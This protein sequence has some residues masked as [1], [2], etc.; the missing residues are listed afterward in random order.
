MRRLIGSCVAVLSIFVSTISAAALPEFVPHDIGVV[1]VKPDLTDCETGSAAWYINRNGQVT[2]TS[3]LHVFSWTEGDESPRS[4]VEAPATGFAEPGGISD[5]GQIVG[6]VYPDPFREPLVAD[7]FSWT[8]TGGLVNLGS[9][10]GTYTSAAAVNNTGQVVGQSSVAGNFAGRAFLWSATATPSMRDLGSLPGAAGTP[11]PGRGPLNADAN[12]I[13][14]NGQVVGWTEAVV[15]FN[16]ETRAFLWTEA[17]GMQD[18][19]ILGRSTSVN[20]FSGSEA[21]GINDRGQV[22]GHSSTDATTIF[23]PITHAFLWTPGRGMQDLGTLGGKSSF[24]TAL[25]SSGQVVGWS[26]ATT[27]TTSP[28]RAFLWTESGGMVALGMLPDGTSSRA[29]AINDAGESVGVMSFGTGDRAVL[30]TPTGMPVDLGPSSQALLDINDRGEIVGSRHSR[31][32]VWRRLVASPTQLAVSGTGVYGAHATLTATLVS[33]GGT[34]A[35]QI[36]TFSVNGS[37]VGSATTDAHGVA[38]LSAV[39]LAGMNAGNYP[40]SASFAGS[41]LYLSSSAQ[42]VLTVQKANQSITFSSA[43]PPSATVGAGFPVE[44]GATSDLPVTVAV[45][46]ACSISGTTV[47]L[48]RPPGVCAITADQAGDANYHPAPQATQTTTVIYDFTGFFRP[49][50]NLPAVNGVKAGSAV[51]VKFSLNGNQTLAVLDGVPTSMAIACGS[52]AG[53]MIEPLE[54]TTSGGLSYDSVTDQ[55]VYVWKTEKAWAGTCRQLV[56]RLADGTLRWANF[57]LK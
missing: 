35:D 31:A 30:W 18:L 21:T 44:A 24:P 23:D 29:H 11:P 57:D 12:A 52:T 54:T 22:I 55:Y 40:V 10:G 27:A 38:T 14:D 4:I 2:G 9:L 45:A 1:C 43:A 16:S 33:A 15:G 36:V 25:N 19:G 47:T 56:V 46:G 5:S 49:V 8:S 37:Q 39:S 53:N 20:A 3:G 48:G 42:G 28:D 13:N 34:P 41:D 51:P 6:R 17:T 7:G 32:T 50:D 26:T